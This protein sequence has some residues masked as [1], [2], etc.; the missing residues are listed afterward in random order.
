M[1]LSRIVVLGVF[2]AVIGTT[3]ISHAQAPSTNAPS[4]IEVLSDTKGVDL[5]P[6]LSEVQSA[7]EQKWLKSMPDE[8]KAPKLQKGM[9]AVTFVVLK[10][11]H[12]DR[13]HMS[14]AHPSGIVPLDRAA[15]TAIRAS[16]PLPALPAAFSDK[17]ITL[18]MKFVYNPTAP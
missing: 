6:Y 9:V 11:G 15:W 16:D 4:A 14:L 10:D 2:C 8:A 5:G 1:L 7:V 17:S 3:L 12:L 18:R 13:T